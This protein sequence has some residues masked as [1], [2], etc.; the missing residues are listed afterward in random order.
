MS[1]M[2]V[3]HGSI[4]MILGCSTVNAAIIQ[5]EANPLGSIAIFA[6]DPVGQSFIAEDATLGQIAFKFQ[7]YTSNPAGD[8]NVTMT[9]YQGN[10]IGG[11]VL[12]SVT[13]DISP[14]FNTLGQYETVFID[15]DF[16]GTNLVVGD[17]YTAAVTA[18]DYQ[19]AIRYGS[20]SYAGGQM[21]YNPS[22]TLSNCSPASDCDLF[23]RVTPVPIPAAIWLFGSGLVG[24]IGV[25]RRRS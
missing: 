24:L 12:A 19:I 18:S 1:K 4:A 10:G 2:H 23:F 8:R 20:D 3:V 21:F 16:G 15:F 13:K 11:T 22:K 6:Y 17:T 7:R 25:A 5:N 9:L 14:V